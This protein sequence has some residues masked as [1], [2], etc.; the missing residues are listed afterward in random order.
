MK[1]VLNHLRTCD[2]RE[3]C[4]HPHCLSSRQILSHWKSCTQTD[5]PVC[6]SL[7]RV[8]PA[9]LEAVVQNPRWREEIMARFQWLIT[10]VGPAHLRI[11]QQPQQQP[12]SSSESEEE[13]RER[14]CVKNCE[15]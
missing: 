11:P 10:F 2:A 9:Y 5:C 4:P 12:Q 13:Q 15:E 14:N 3:N 8:V 7:R 1:T 6:S